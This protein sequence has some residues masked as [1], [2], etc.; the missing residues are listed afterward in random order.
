MPGHPDLALGVAGLEE[1]EQ[2]RVARL[3]EAFVA[4]GEQPPAPVERVVL[5]AA[6]A[7][8]LLLDPAAHVVEAGVGQLD[9]VERVRDLGGVG[10][11]CR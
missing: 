10:E 9:H 7:E 5:V 3:V 6:V 8:G 11:A 4:L 2:L 1:A